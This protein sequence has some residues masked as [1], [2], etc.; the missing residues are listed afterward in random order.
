MS[1]AEVSRERVEQRLAR[2]DDA[3]D[4]FTVNQT[5]LSVSEAAY[6]RARNRCQTSLI[7]AYVQVYDD[8]GDVLLVADDDGAV[9]PHAQLRRETEL[10]DGARE[11]VRDLTG[12][13]C[14]VTGLRRVTIL[15][16]CDED[17][18]ECSPVYRLVT[19]LT[20]ERTGGSPDP[21]AGWYDDVPESAFP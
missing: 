11:V 17:A 13:D 5:T 3:F 16:V 14:E 6:E 4:S 19:V 2:L 15:G 9:V 18:P 8:D 10:R 7:D 12:V 1:V 20:A 21:D